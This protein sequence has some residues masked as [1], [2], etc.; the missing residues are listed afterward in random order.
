MQMIRGISRLWRRKGEG[1]V[2]MHDEEEV[3]EEGGGR[4]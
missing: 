4:A 1:G 2:I 3:G